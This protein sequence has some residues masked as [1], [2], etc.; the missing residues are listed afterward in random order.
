MV[1]YGNLDDND[2]LFA[3]IITIQQLE[4]D[5]EMEE[6]DATYNAILIV[7]DIK[8]ARMSQAIIGPLI[9]E[10][11]RLPSF[12]RTLSFPFLSD[13]LQPRYSLSGI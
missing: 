1:L 10:Y 2:M 9:Q 6:E 5:L 3:S 12:S 4:A 11:E 7:F 13:S 8:S